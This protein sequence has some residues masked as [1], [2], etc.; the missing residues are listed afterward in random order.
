MNSRTFLRCRP[1]LWGAT[2]A[3]CLFSGFVVMM[4]KIP[5]RAPKGG[6]A[7]RVAQRSPFSPAAFPAGSG[8]QP[9]LVEAYGKLPLSFEIN[10]GQA[11]SQVKFLSRGSGYALF[12]TGNEAVLSLTKPVQKA[13]GKRQMAKG[14]APAFRP[15]HQGS[16]DLFSPAFPALLPTTEEFKDSF[17]PRDEA[18]IPNPESRAPAVLRMKLVGANERAKVTGLEELPGKS[19]YFI[20]NDPKKWR[21]NVPNYAKVKYAGVYPG[22][23]LVYYGNRGSGVTPWVL[24]KF[25]EKSRGGRAD[26]CC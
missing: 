25:Y 1:V 24:S 11:H 19:N 3:A 8:V 26:E 12:L 7:A 18:G 13:S 10:K 4:S 17:A 21:T 6:P 2:I 16:A 23:D 15:A 5:L 14:V 22:V 20:G 9:R